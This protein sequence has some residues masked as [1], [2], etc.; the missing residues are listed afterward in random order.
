MSNEETFK[1]VDDILEHYGWGGPIKLVEVK[2][3]E[4]SADRSEALPADGADSK[5]KRDTDGDIETGVLNELRQS[6]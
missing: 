6:R 4:G 2:K 1:S 5:C 3:D